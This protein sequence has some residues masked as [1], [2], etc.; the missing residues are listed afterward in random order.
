MIK[1]DVILPGRG[2]MTANDFFNSIKGP[3]LNELRKVG[4]NDIRADFNATVATWVKK[5]KFEV[6]PSA[7]GN[8]LG[9]SIRPDDMPIEGYS[10]DATHDDASPGRIW[11]WID[12]GTGSEVGRKKYPIE[13]K[14][15][16]KELCLP[17]FYTPKTTPKFVGSGP[18]GEGKSHPSGKKVLHPGIKPRLWTEEIAK[19]WTEKM[20]WIAAQLQDTMN[21]L[22]KKSGLGL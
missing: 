4:R 5:P 17:A 6:H 14:D 21:D 13:V 16:T 1:F 9:I 2:V 7:A 11:D 3:M 20:P 19:Q 22:V 15:E 10:G 12:R 18:G 8:V